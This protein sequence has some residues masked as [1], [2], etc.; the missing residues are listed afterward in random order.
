MVDIS[1]F[2][3]DRKKA[4]TVSSVAHVVDKLHEAG[5][6]TIRLHEPR[7]PDMV[8]LVVFP[9]GDASRPHT[10]AALV[11]DADHWA[12]G[13]NL[14]GAYFDYLGDRWTPTGRL[15]ESVLTILAGVA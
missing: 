13:P 11:F 1:R 3:F 12:A 9:V 15:V 5:V 4:K 6:M 8:L 2:P 10:S 14:P 7:R